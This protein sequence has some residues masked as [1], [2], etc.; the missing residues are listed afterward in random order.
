MRPEYWRIRRVLPGGTQTIKESDEERAREIER[1]A[2]ELQQL[3]LLGQFKPG[4][5]TLVMRTYAVHTGKLLVIKAEAGHLIRGGEIVKIRIERD[6]LK[7]HRLEYVNN[8]HPP[9]NPEKI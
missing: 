7:S 6:A 5:G 1:K 8:H 3:A 4:M 9:L 2:G